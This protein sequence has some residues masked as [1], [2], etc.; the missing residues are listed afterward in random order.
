MTNEK[1]KKMLEAKLKCFIAE[2]SGT[3]HDCNMRLC[4]GCALNYEQ[5]NMGEQKQALD[6]AIQA[7]ER[8]SCIKEKCAYCP[9]C[10]HCDVDDETLEIKALEQQPS[11]DCISRQAVIDLT[12][13]SDWFESSDDYND[14]VCA[15][16]DLPSVTPK[17]EY[18][19]KEIKIK[20]ECDDCISRQ[21]VIQKINN[22]LN[23]CTDM[24]KC[25]EM[26]EIKEDVENL[27]SVKPTRP[28]GKW[29]VLDECA[30]EGVYCSKCHKTVFKLE[31]NHTMKWRNFKYCPNCG[32]EMEVEG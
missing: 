17:S 21:A 30:N 25:L 28:K 20:F 3:N 1:A 32:A 2:T 5:G 22:K 7:L 12:G 19:W 14:F 16:C 23:P 18:S 26:S 9:H 29:I 24:F 4:D 15:V 8:A 31:F 11:E 10:E 13:K 27:P 6:I